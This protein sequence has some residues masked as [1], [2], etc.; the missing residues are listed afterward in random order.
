MRKW[1]L[2]ILLVLLVLVGCSDNKNSTLSYEE[3][4]K[5]MVDTLQTE[6][7]KKAMQQLLADPKFQEQLVL[8]K[9]GKNLY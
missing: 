6:E 8:K 5:I 3:I 1:M 2:I 4:Q 9:N 7:G